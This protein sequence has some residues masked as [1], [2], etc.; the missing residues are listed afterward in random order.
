M[1]EASSLTFFTKK[2]LNYMV[3][4]PGQ[5]IPNPKETLATTVW[6]QNSTI[7]SPP[8]NK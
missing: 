3:I 5:I 7:A 6:Y 4:L 8:C 1:C 2:T